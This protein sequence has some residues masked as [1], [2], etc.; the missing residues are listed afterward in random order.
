[1]HV[2]LVCAP[3]GAADHDWESQSCDAALDGADMKNM[4]REMVELVADCFKALA[5]PARLRLL[6][7]LRKGEMTVGELVEATEL[8]QANVSKHLALLHQLG[9]VRRRKEGLFSYYMLADTGIIQLCDIM[10]GRVEQ[11]VASQSRT[12]AG[13][14]VARRR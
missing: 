3:D 1:M 9:Y 2:R 5:D 8:G 4:S 12:V 14:A 11:R 7:E 10:C 13:R 6:V